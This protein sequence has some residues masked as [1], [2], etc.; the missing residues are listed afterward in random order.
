[1]TLLEQTIIV[2]VHI[3]LAIS[4]M[5]YPFFTKRNILFGIKIPINALNDKKN[6]KI[7]YQFI[8]LVG[9]IG[10]IMATLGF[11]YTG[12]YESIILIFIS[13]LIYTGIYLYAHFQMKDLKR[14]SDWHISD[15]VEII[16]DTSFRSQPLII[17]S[18]CY[19]LYLVILIIT[20]VVI[21]M[22][23]ESLPDMLSMQTN[24]L[25]EKVTLLAKG[26]V[27]LYL[28][29]I[30]SAVMALMIFIQYVIKHGKQ[31]LSGSNIKYSV[32][33]NIKFRQR[34][35]KILYMLGLI[36]GLDFMFSIFFTMEIIQST[37]L[38]LMLTLGSVLILIIYLFLSSFKYG[39]DGSRLNKII[40]ES[41]NDFI[42]NEDDKYWFL[43]MI[44]FNKNDPS[45][46]I[47]KRVGIGWSVN[48]ARWQA[49]LFYLVI[50]VF[51]IIIT[52]MI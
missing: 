51:L 45:V 11:F 26:R 47:S 50:L 49:W 10:I 8:I 41:S 52:V 35:S 16:I 23:F 48:H 5:I 12:I 24:S 21:Q 39:Q 43:G 25:G 1:M 28:V 37:T 14:N 40:E 46:F 6:L 7:K 44:Y 42:D 19:I 27:L 18:K 38:F 36:V 31:D 30:Q 34:F 3:I 29:G 9:I 22:K 17:S 4:F 13:I 32:E 20:V 15:H 2:F 33:E